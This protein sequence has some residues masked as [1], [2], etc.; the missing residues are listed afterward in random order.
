MPFKRL[1][2]IKPYTENDAYHFKRIFRTWKDEKIPNHWLEGVT[3]FEEK[4]PD[5]EF[6]LTTDED[7]R[8]FIAENYPDYLKYY[9]AFP[10]NIQKCDFVRPFLLYQWAFSI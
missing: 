3:S 6:V 2:D 9:D 8:N 4:L 1:K 5:Y 10:Y 7:N